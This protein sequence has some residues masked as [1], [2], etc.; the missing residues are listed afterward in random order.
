MKFLTEMSHELRKTNDS[1]LSTK[2]NEIMK[3]LTLMS[4]VAFPLTVIASIFGMNSNLPI[5]GQ[6]NDFLI[7]LGIMIATAIF[8]FGIFK[9]KK[10]L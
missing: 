8:L 4:F 3:V 10:W 9:F 5:V 7:I 2:Q 1:L 6:S